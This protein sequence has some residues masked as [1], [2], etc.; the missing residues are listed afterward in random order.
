MDHD[1]VVVPARRARGMMRRDHEGHWGS[2]NLETEGW[3]TAATRLWRYTH[4][5][6]QQ[7]QITMQM[8][9]MTMGI[10][11]AA[12]RIPPTKAKPAAMMAPTALPKSWQLPLVW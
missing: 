9:T 1:D 11:M 7:T 10:T 12:I 2:I 6:Q 8:I 5:Q 4:L 3:M